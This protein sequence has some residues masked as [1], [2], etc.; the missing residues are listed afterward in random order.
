[1]LPIP[2][3]LSASHCPLRLLP[4]HLSDMTLA[5]GSVCLHRSPTL[6]AHED[7]LLT[8]LQL[9]PQQQSIAHVDCDTNETGAVEKRPRL[10][11][12]RPSQNRPLFCSVCGHCKSGGMAVF[13]TQRVACGSK[14][15][16][17]IPEDPDVRAVVVRAHRR[18][19]IDHDLFRTLTRMQAIQHPQGCQFC[20]REEW[21]HGGAFNFE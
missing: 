18:K 6:W 11:Q 5:P 13:H 3:S 8:W 16:C 9:R 10:T 19:R 12:R 15:E 1:M 4:T 17:S 14:G 21:S 2:A 7:S 20:L